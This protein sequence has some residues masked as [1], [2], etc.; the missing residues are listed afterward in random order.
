[1]EQ[2][3]KDVN[4]TISRQDGVKLAKLLSITNGEIV[5]LAMATNSALVD[6]DVRS[7]ISDPSWAEVAIQH[8]HVA[9]QLAIQ[10]NISEAYSLQNTM[11]G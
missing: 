1:M 4:G 5:S 7:L 11:L 2:F 6:R 10:H 9:F 3:I 8:W